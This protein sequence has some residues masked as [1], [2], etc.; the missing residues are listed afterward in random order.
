MF[1]V[2]FYC[3]FTKNS[4]DVTFQTSYIPI[5]LISVLIFALIFNIVWLILHKV[6]QLKQAK[7]LAMADDTYG[8][9]ESSSRKIDKDYILQLKEQIKDCIVIKGFD[10]KGDKEMTPMRLLE[11]IKH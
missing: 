5:A 10:E 7:K 6:R 9:E 4:K 8:D 1:G 3:N 11:E 2:Y